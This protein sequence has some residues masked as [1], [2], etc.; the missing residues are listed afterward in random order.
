MD[1]VV[2][3]NIEKYPTESSK[4]EG[5]IIRIIGNSS[6]SNI[7]A[8]SLY[9]SYGL[10]KLENLMSQ[11]KM[12]VNKISQN[13]LFEQKRDRIDRTKE[14]VYTIDAADAKDLDDAVCVKKQD[15]G[16]YILSVYIADVSYYVKEDSFL[17]KEAISRGTSIYI[18][19]KVIPMLP[20]ELSNGICSHN[21][22]VD[23]LTLGVDIFIS[24]EGKSSRFTNF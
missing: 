16:S 7:D 21:E 14:R 1:R 24:K 17:D 18:P 5:R 6:D 15:D 20:K 2:Q 8:K 12:K 11:F 19:G 4:A 3:V 9:V 22:G 10:D 23:R 13:V